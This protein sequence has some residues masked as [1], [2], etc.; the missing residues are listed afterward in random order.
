MKS[1]TRRW[2][3]EVVSIICVIFFLLS[4]TLISVIARSYYGRVNTALT[5]GTTDMLP[6]FFTLYGN[7]DAESFATVGREFIED[8]SAKELM[9]VWIINNE[10]SVILSSG[11]FDVKDPVMPDYQE[12]LRSE[13]GRSVWRGR[14]DA[15]EHIMAETRTFRY[16]DG[17]MAG[18]VRF[19]TSLKDIDNQLAKISV[20]IFS[21]TAGFLAL[22]IFISTRFLLR[23]VIGPVR[24]VCDATSRLASGDL[25]AR[26]ENYRENDEIG[27][28]CKT[29]NDMAAKLSAAD[30]MKNDFI[31]TVSHELRTPLTA[32]RGWG[33]TLLQL[34]DTDPATSRRGME[35]IVDE[36]SRLNDMVEDLLDFSRINTGR[37]KLNIEKIDV[38]AE[39]D[40]IV[41]AFRDR[42][43]KEGIELNYNVPHI[44]VPADGD[45]A[46]IRQ[47]FINILDNALKYNRQGGRVTVAAVIK[48]PKT[49]VI[50]I[51]DNG[52][53]ISPEDLPKVKDKFFKADSTVRGSGIGLAV[54]DEIMKLHNGEFSIDSILGEGTTVTLVLPT[55]EIPEEKGVV[56]PDEQIEE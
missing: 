6:S 17:S 22:F 50:S 7:K 47:V 40:E 4:V 26:I 48:H 29:V 56:I 28:L 15:G 3:A 52:K 21:V 1:I 35:V 53:G 41:F 44:P 24:Q 27:N 5:S 16:A 10:G 23:S 33:E 42:A 46:R 34:G 51:S 14:T 2:V 18:A 20:L 49:V 12:A 8:F 30:R 55:D 38:L 36:T 11:G 19:V 31:S 25:E 13:M 43:K 9:E 37:M 45:A 54:V 39:L 32:I